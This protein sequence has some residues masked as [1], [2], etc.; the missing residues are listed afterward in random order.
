MQRICSF[1]AAFLLLANIAAAQNLPISN[2]FLLET[3]WRDSILLFKNPQFLTGFNKLGYNNQPAFI[4]ND[5]L[6][7][8]VGMNNES[9]TSTCSI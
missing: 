7:I 4:S 1:L 5:E 3:E 8:T 2:I 6:L 9:Q